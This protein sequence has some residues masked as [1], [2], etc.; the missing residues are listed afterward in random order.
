ML[1]EVLF[2]PTANWFHKFIIKINAD[3]STAGLQTSSGPE[4]DCSPAVEMSAFD[5]EF[6]KPIHGW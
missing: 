5:D 2:L 4:E 6:V 3:V 1:I